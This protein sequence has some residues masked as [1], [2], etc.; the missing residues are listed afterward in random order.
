M[1]D[2]G[3]LRVRGSGEALPLRQGR[4]DIERLLRSVAGDCGCS[5]VG[6]YAAGERAGPAWMHASG[7]RCH[8]TCMAGMLGACTDR[9][10]HPLPSW[11]GAGPKGLMTSVQLAVSRI[12]ADGTAGAYLELHR[13]AV[14]L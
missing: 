10:P 13:E 11:C 8:R 5:S 12:N 14:E 1:Q 3:C 7:G 4:P 2:K 6:V 9:S